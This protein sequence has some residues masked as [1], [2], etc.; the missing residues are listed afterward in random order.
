MSLDVNTLRSTGG[1]LPDFLTVD[2]AARVAR[3]GRTVAYRLARQYLATAG[4]EGLPVVRFGKQLRVPRP[5]LEAML[6]GTLTSVPRADESAPAVDV[7]AIDSRR[8]SPTPS[9][10]VSRGI[11]AVSRPDGDEHP[12]LFPARR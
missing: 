12:R 3:I 1:G 10:S 8:H 4:R 7:I 2:E 6:G 5:A 9:Q 11:P